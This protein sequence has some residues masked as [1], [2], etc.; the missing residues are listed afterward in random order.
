[1]PNGEPGEDLE[2]WKEIAFRV[3]RLRAAVRTGEQTDLSEFGARE[4]PGG[5][6]IDF[7]SVMSKEQIR[8]AAER[9]DA[10]A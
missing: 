7:R 8:N 1:M 2:L 9:P 3:R 10:L 4:R 5:I 6:G